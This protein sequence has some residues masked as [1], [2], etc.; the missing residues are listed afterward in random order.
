MQSLLQ[1]HCVWNNLVRFRFQS[2]KPQLKFDSTIVFSKIHRIWNQKAQEWLH[3]HGPILASKSWQSLLLLWKAKVIR[4]GTKRRWAEESQGL[5]METAFFHTLIKLEEK[6]VKHP[7]SCPGVSFLHFIPLQKII[8]Y[9]FLFPHQ[10][11]A[12]MHFLPG[13]ADRMYLD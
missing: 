3:F 10:L 5:L 4:K 13:E 9:N 8:K 2:M 12:K 6:S 1:S 11:K 7:I